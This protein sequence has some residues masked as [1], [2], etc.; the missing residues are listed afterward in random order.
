MMKVTFIRTEPSRLLCCFSGK[1]LAKQV[2]RCSDSCQL[3]FVHLSGKFTWF[4]SFHKCPVQK[5]GRPLVYHKANQSFHMC[6]LVLRHS[7]GFGVYVR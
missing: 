5:C 1:L 2:G 3:V 7:M 4:Q 6:G